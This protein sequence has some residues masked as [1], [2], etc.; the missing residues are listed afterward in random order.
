M[1]YFQ[2]LLVHRRE[3]LIETSALRRTLF[4]NCWTHSRPLLAYFPYIIR[5]THS[6]FSWSDHKKLPQNVQ[7]IAANTEFTVSV[8]QESKSG[9][10]G[11]SWLRASPDGRQAGQGSS[12]PEA[13]W[14]GESASMLTHGAGGLEATGA[15]P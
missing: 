2:S 5:R 10:A 9:L 8:G 12:H 14:A 11:L 4:P 7:V 1:R 3:K 13:D 15:S 6:S